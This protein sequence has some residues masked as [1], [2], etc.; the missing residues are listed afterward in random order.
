MKINKVLELDEIW[1]RIAINE[2]NK[3]SY[4]ILS[5]ITFYFSLELFYIKGL[6]I[7]PVVL[8]IGSIAFGII[9]FTCRS[10]VKELEKEKTALIESAIDNPND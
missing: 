7:T 4:L 8:L 2:F 5:M 1:G 3:G 9:S 6:G 10:R